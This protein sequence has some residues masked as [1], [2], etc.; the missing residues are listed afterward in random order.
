MC[1]EERRI[2]DAVSASRTWLF[3]AARRAGVAGFEGEGESGF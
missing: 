2:F 1:E 3:D